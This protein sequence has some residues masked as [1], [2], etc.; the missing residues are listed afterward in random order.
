MGPK[1][2]MPFLFVILALTV[3]VSRIA[4]FYLDIPVTPT[5]FLTPLYQNLFGSGFQYQSISLLISA[6]FMLFTGLVM[7]L[8]INSLWIFESRNIMP[9][10]LSMI[11]LS[12]GS[13][14]QLMSDAYFI[15][16]LVLFS[17][18][19]LYNSEKIDLSSRK[20]FNVSMLIATGSLF[21]FYAIYILPLYLGLFVFLRKA[22]LK[23][24][25]AI[26]T[27]IATPYWILWGI[28]FLTN[29]TETFQLYYK[30]PEINL[31]SLQ[32]MTDG[33]LIY[34]PGLSLLGIISFTSFL[35]EYQKMKQTHRIIY[36]TSNMLII[37]TLIIAVLGIIPIQHAIS[38]AVVSFSFLFTLYYHLASKRW[39]WIF[40]ISFLV[41]FSSSFI[42][43]F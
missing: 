37:Y 14:L 11:L 10:F 39:V 42:I 23:L 27:G 7:Y 16:I 22:T 25:L 34:L 43:R 8:V 15:P 12:S 35:R 13:E 6:V 17:L 21:S 38:L 19:L 3:L 20:I 2:S 28:L 36:L 31:I 33:F 29:K 30:I 9:V 1:K 32:N 4:P 18:L 24:F 26:L 41:F 40:F 5:P